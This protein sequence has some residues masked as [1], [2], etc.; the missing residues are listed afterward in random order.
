MSQTLLEALLGAGIPLTAAALLVGLPPAKLEVGFCVTVARGISSSSSSLVSLREIPLFSSSG[1]SISTSLSFTTPPFW[2]GLEARAA[3]TEGTTDTLIFCFIR[4]SAIGSESGTT[5]IAS[6]VNDD[7]CG[8]A[9][10]VIPRSSGASK[11]GRER[12]VECGK[13]DPI[14]PP[15]WT[16]ALASVGGIATLLVCGDDPFCWC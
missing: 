5:S 1:A 7:C 3:G 11:G 6:L 9:L 13:G 8:R 15:R 12:V 10:P 16:E 4:C 2:G 14:S